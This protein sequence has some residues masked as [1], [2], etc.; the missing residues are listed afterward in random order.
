MSNS[1]GII[2]V[3]FWWGAGTAFVILLWWFGNVLVMCWWC[4]GE[5]VWREIIEDGFYTPWL[6]RVGG[7]LQWCS[8]GRQTGP[9]VPPW[10]ASE[11]MVVNRPSQAGDIG[12][13]GS[14]WDS[15]SESLLYLLWHVPML[16]RIVFHYVLTYFPMFSATILNIICMTYLDILGNL[17]EN[18][19]F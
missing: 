8:G 6:G 4:V 17:F 13:N 7:L 9:R 11:N 14:K 10:R 18:S 2:F 19:R 3:M 15:K 12:A 1:I 16:F 5:V